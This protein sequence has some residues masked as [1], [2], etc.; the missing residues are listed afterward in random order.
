MLDSGIIKRIE[1]F[2]Y[3][4][5]RSVQEIARHIDKNWRT[6]DRYIEEIE[7]NF[8]TISTRVFR[9]GTRGALKIVY[10]A[11]VEKAS[12]SVF[13][14]KLEKEILS[15]KT[16]DDFAAFDIYQH[17][18]DP[19]KK[20]TAEKR[21]EPNLTNL[22]ELSDFMLATQ[23]QMLIFSGNLSFTNLKNG[24]VDMMEIFEKLIKK[25][26]PIKILCRVDIIGKDNIEKL[27]SLNYKHG[28]ELIEI[29][30]CEHPIR[31]IITDSDAFRI[32]QI[33]EPTGKQRELEQTLFIFYTIYNKDWTQWLSRIFWK[34]F[35]SSIDANKRLQEINKIKII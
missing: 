15:G 21:G 14:E 34:L 8:G 25:N 3:S 20:V 1:E 32:K 35:S 26:I 2:V 17:V 5:P 30:H 13:Q 27:L 10:W 9:G 28:K 29:R 11:S 16:K 24:D 7:K 6:A 19:D 22:R 18:L 4:Q 12:S 33:Q 31:A 23:K